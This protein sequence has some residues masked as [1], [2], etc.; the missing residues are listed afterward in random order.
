MSIFVLLLIY[1]SFEHGETIANVGYGPDTC[2]IVCV[3]ISSSLL[4]REEH[5]FRAV[6]FVFLRAD[7]EDFC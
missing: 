7:P 5:T 1:S 2:T 3:C 4:V 6:V